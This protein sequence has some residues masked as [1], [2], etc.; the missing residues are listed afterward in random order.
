MDNDSIKIS[1][2]VVMGDVQHNVTNVQQHISTGIECPRCDSKNVRIMGCSTPNCKSQFCELCH[3]ECRW[4]INGRSRFDSGHGRGPFCGLC[5]DRH[6]DDWRL[7]EEISGKRNQ[8]NHDKFA[9]IIGFVIMVVLSVLIPVKLIWVI[10]GMVELGLV[11]RY[12]LSWWDY[13]DMDKGEL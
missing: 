5:M 1:D 6:M 11:V 9:A 2:S 13:T 8:M 3:P 7:S 10:V 12:L 4:S